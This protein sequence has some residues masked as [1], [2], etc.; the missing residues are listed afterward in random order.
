MIAGEAV[1]GP[2]ERQRYTLA[3]CLARRQPN[4]NKLSFT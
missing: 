3:T 1:R 4:K 2:A